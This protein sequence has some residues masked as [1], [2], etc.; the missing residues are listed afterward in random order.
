MPVARSKQLANMATCAAL[1]AVAI[2]V[3]AFVPTPWGVGQFRP[4]VVIPVIYGFLAGSLVA[5]VGAAVGTLIGSFILQAAGTGLGPLGSL[6]SGVP[7]NFI[8]FYLLGLFVNKW[9][10]WNGFILGTFVSLMIG[11]L[12]AAGGVAFYLTYVF[13]RWVSMVFEVKLATVL[14]L[15]LFWTVTMLPFV[16][17]IVPLVIVALS[18]T[19]FS[20]MGS[21]SYFRSASMKD[22]AGP[23]VIVAV[24]LGITYVLI[25]VTS[26]GNLMFASVVSEANIFWVKS[27]FA[28]SAL[29]MIGFAVVG[30]LLVAKPYRKS[31]HS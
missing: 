7:A 13:P 27:L 4:G 10:S 17:V 24:I 6:I 19:G 2:A 11:N 5:G 26:V 29:I 15:T 8:G 22:V 3:T 12:V 14:G 20:N 23:S 28:L 31:A 25:V 21:F 30:V 16:L 18:R 1:Y 9:K